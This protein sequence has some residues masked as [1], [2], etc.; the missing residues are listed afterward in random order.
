MTA[1]LKDIAEYLNISVSTVS[2]VINNKNRVDGETREMVLK[3]LEKFQYSPNEIARSLKSKTTKAIGLI[4]PDISNYFFSMVLKGVEA[5]VRKHGYYL[6]LCNSD[7]DKEREKEYVKFL[8]QKQISGLIIAIEG[9]EAS[10]FVQ[11][12]KLGIP[13]VF[14][15]NLPKIDENYDYVAIDNKKAGYELVNHLI[16]AGHS[17][18]AIITGLLNESTASERYKGWEKALLEHDIPIKKKWIG[19]GDFKQESGYHIMQDFLKQ[20]EIVTAV[21]AANNL[22]AYGA[23][24]AIKEAGLKVPDDISVVC[25]DAIDFTGLLKPQITSVIQPAEEIGRIAGEIIIRKILNTGTKIFERIVLEPQLEI[26]ESC[27]YYN[28]MDK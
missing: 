19:I 9:F 22:L 21:F 11:Y 13:V 10:F 18:I 25:F 20:E 12:K 6:I 8:L 27:W 2:R 28:K 23:M 24:H 17:K 15:D 16:E 14:I 1:K 5:E 26:K 4:V 3:A 7:E